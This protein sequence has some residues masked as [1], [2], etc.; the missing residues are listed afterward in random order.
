MRRDSA[1]PTIGFLSTYS[2][3]EGASIDSYA[4]ALLQGIC[5]AA[6]EYDCN[7]LLGCGI[8]TDASREYVV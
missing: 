6:R 4:H 1:R 3:Y 8:S 5:A 2:V 7:L